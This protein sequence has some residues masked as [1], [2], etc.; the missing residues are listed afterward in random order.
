MFIHDSK[1]IKRNQLMQIIQTNGFEIVK[2]EQRHLSKVEAEEF[3]KE[4]KGKFFYQRLISF[5]TR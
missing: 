4:H 5:M 2:S 3:Y 1:Q